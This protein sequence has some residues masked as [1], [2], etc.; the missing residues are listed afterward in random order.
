MKVSYYPGCSLHGTAKEYDQSV[1]AVSKALGI[2]LSEVEDWS[3][4][5][6]T[7]A[8]STNFKLSVAL[9]ARNLAAVEA[10]PQKEVMVPCAACFNRFKSTQYYLGHNEAL[11]REIEGVIGRPYRGDAEVL[12][13]LGIFHDRVGLEGLASRVVKKLT[14]LKPVSYYGCLLL[15]PPEACRFEDYE[16][17]YMLDGILTALGAEVKMW[18]YKT[19]CCGGSL[20]ISRTDIVG[21]LVDKLMTMA[22]EAGANCVVT[23]CPV[24]MANLDT[25]AGENVR[26]P[27][28]Y[29]TELMALAFGL[30]GPADWFK[31]HNTDPTPLMG[32]LGL[33]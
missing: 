17:P 22:R 5:G 33:V 23:A 16:N 3:C 32:G 15:R 6:A 25:R 27:V 18:S 26:L 29:F 12:H 10:G 1:K 24:C 19:D 13:P 31:L 2:E 30:A 8:H 9:P 7:S 21:R 28:F 11:K 20:T 14:G 4:C